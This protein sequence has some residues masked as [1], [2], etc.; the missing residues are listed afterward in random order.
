MKPGWLGYGLLGLAAIAALA[1]RVVTVTQ[2]TQYGCRPIDH[3][4][5]L[6]LQ[7]LADAP[8]AAALPNIE[9]Q[10]VELTIG[11]PPNSDRDS[12]LTIVASYLTSGEQS[13]VYGGPAAASVQVALPK[14]KTDPKPEYILTV[15]L[16]QPTRLLACAWST[17][18]PSEISPAIAKNW[19]I[20]LADAPPEAP[21]MASLWI[22]PQ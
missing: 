2:S 20:T 3:E 19:K 14:R 1:I 17:D 7:G 18:Q 13:V 11:L 22:A 8:P 15:Q 12:R 4:E 16:L 5:L 10:A 21:Q 9:Y 6:R